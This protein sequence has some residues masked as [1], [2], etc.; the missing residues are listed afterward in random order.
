MNPLA[1][2]GGTAGYVAAALLAFVVMFSFFIPK[3]G[4]TF[5]NPL[6]TLT[7]IGANLWLW[8]GTSMLGILAA[9]FGV[10]FTVGLWSR[11]RERAPSRAAAAL[12]LE[13]IGLAGY[14]LSS[15]IMWKGGIAMASYAAKDPAA[16][17]TAWLALRYAAR[18]ATDL[19][20]AFVG[21][22]LI[23]AGW[24]MVAT[25]AMRRTVG[26]VAVL[27]GV[28]TILAIFPLSAILDLAGAV[29]TVVWLA[30]AGGELR[31]A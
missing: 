3:I 16:A 21:A 1:R 7:F 31:R 30:W 8:R 14:A 27:T 20:H 2:N 26:Y 25:G 18:A 10:L 5:G 23:I 9:A 15:L 28:F 4:A 13:L 12:A 24:A 6:E 17:A 29:L 19:G 11:L 22:A